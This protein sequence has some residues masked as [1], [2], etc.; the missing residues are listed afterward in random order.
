MVQLLGYVRVVCRA[1]ERAITATEECL[2]ICNSATLL[3]YNNNNNIGLTYT[4]HYILLMWT[5]IA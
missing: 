3:L 4:S 2:A 1:S 5:A